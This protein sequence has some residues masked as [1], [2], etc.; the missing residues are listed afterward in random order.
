MQPRILGTIEVIVGSVLVISAL[1]WFRF[2]THLTGKVETP[3]MTDGEDLN[4][5]LD[6]IP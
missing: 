6:M 3:T 1:F 2:L 4:R 5:R